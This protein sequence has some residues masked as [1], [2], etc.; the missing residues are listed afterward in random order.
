MM[1]ILVAPNAFKGTI[2]A[3][4]AGE[5]LSECL[6]SRFPDSSIELCPIADGGDG[7]CDLLGKS[8][9]LKKL[10]T[11]ALDAVGKFKQGFIYL[12]NGQKEAL[13]DIS[14]VSGLQGL[15]S[16]EVDARVTSSYG[17]GLLIRR[18][19]EEGA[20][21]LILGLGGSATVDMGTGILRALG[22][23]F[24]D[25]KGREIPVYSPD[26][27]NQIAHIQLPVKKWDI[28][29]TCLCDVNNTFFG[30]KG[31]VPVFGPQKGLEEDG[32]M[33]FEKGAARLFQ[34]M[35]RKS[36]RNLADQPGFGAAGGIALG[37]SAFFPVDI[38]VGA[39]YFFDQVN[40]EEKLKKAD[41]VITG[42]G[43]FDQQS[44][45]GKASYELL[46]MAKRLGKKT[47][48][49]TSGD[50]KEALSAGFDKVVLLPDLDLSN[51]HV[52]SKAENNLKE[53]MNQF[54]K[55]GE[56]G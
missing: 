24:L 54:L 37:L 48:M 14:S 36:K 44:A 25:K 10:E 8:L 42:E 29:F 55:K 16:F 27:L 12:N 17:T 53:A 15:K 4:R 49:I 50:G 20:E 47:V 39:R 6:S 2:T 52:H 1:K 33:A 21:R 56:L 51:T 32:L 23:V 45:G 35:Q 11:A 30:D 34:L 18:A 26:F 22:F 38:K 9:Q 40:M 43:R 31:A 3:A 13:L 46:Q 19:I 7:T 28:R 41:W 5:L